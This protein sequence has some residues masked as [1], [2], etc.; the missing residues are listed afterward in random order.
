MHVCS[1]R[2]VDGLVLRYISTAFIGHRCVHLC[3]W[4]LVRQLMLLKPFSCIATVLWQSVG[5]DRIRISA[6]VRHA[7]RH[8][9]ADN[10]RSRFL[11]C[12]NVKL[13]CYSIL[14]FVCVHCVFA[15][16]KQTV[17]LYFKS[18]KFCSAFVLHSFRL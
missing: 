10:L 1:P 17:A 8:P 6:L 9:G 4:R 14:T 7:A 16:S 12:L 5:L 2:T 3:V 11:I 18:C 15:L 13:H